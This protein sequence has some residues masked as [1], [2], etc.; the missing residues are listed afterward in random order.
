MSRRNRSTNRAQYLAEKLSEQMKGDGD[1]REKSAEMQSTPDVEECH[2]VVAWQPSGWQEVWSNIVHMRSARDAP[3]DLVGAESYMKQDLPPALCRLHVLVHLV[4]SS[5]TRDEENAAAICRLRSSLPGGLCIDSLLAVDQQLLQQLICPVGFYRRK[6]GYLKQ[7]A[8]ILRADYR[9]DLP[10]SVTELCQLPG[11]GP[12]M[13][14]ICMSAAWNTVTGIAVDTH[15]HR[16]CNLLGWVQHPTKD[17]LK[18]QKSIESWIPRHLW[19]EVNLV[20]VGFGQQICQSRKP[21]C[22]QCTN[23]SICPSSRCKSSVSSSAVDSG[24]KSKKKRV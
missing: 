3:V 12:K 22:D 13:A 15:V 19:K 21:L 2:S 9:D 10:R 14:H 4:L 24:Q 23:K 6:A 8:A 5:Q 16:I 1:D 20:L 11:V 18:T 17:Q 7:I